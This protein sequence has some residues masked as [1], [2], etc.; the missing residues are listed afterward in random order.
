MSLEQIK[1][2]DINNVDDIKYFV[3]ELKKE[4][5]LGPAA[6]SDYLTEAFIDE[7]S[8]SSLLI[9]FYILK[10][11]SQFN[12]YY[13][14]NNYTFSSHR[15]QAYVGQICRIISNMKKE[16]ITFPHFADF[17]AKARRILSQT[18]ISHKVVIYA[19]NNYFENKLGSGSIPS[20][21]TL[22]N[23]ESFKLKAMY[24]GY[25]EFINYKK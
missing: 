10:F 3:S 11:L 1:R 2:L 13:T 7:K 25:V 23:E 12:S 16:N 5:S 19:L 21:T 6:I 24:S 15:P 22:L 9:W 18:S 17:K 14:N 20:L 8:S 4:I